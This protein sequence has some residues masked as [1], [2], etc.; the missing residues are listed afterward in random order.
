MVVRFWEDGFAAYRARYGEFWR[1]S[2]V[3]SRSI[4]EQVGDLSLYVGLS[5]LER[6]QFWDE[7]L[8]AQPEFAP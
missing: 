6:E 5:Q 8:N 2:D 4:L 7:L 1:I 3:E